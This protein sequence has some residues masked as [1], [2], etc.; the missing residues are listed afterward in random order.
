M[1]DID[2]ALPN[3]RTELKVP[4]PEQDVEIQEQEQQKGPVEVTPEED[5]GATIDFEPVQLIKQAQNHTS[6]TLQIFYQK[7]L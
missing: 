7:I 1:A 5:G 6:I 2:K 3:T 4:G